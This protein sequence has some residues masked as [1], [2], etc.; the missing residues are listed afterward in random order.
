MKKLL[1]LI[2]AA[3]M[4]MA[5][6]ALAE[7]LD[8]SEMTLDELVKLHTL[9]HNELV[10]R[11][12]DNRA[13]IYTGDYLAGTDIKP[14][15]YLITCTKKTYTN[16]DMT[17]AVY[18]SGEDYDNY[19]HMDPNYADFKKHAASLSQII[20]GESAIVRVEAGDYL[21]IRKGEGLCIPYQGTWAP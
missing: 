6:P 13:M 10:K 14:G 18:H 12:D 1:S 21:I 2:L 8:P 20:K 5:M 17:I 4:L 3:L 9:I 19:A 11:I 15:V 7:E 16:S